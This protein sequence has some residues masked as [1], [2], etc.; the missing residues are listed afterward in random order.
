MARRTL[1]SQ[2]ELARLLGVQRS[3]VL[4]RLDYQGGPIPTYK[5]G[6]KRLVDKE[7]ALSLWSS[8]KRGQG[9]HPGATPD[10]PDEPD[11][12]ETD[13]LGDIF[14][15]NTSPVSAPAIPAPPS[16]GQ[17]TAELRLAILATKALSDK[18]AVERE[19]GNLVDKALAVRQVYSYA[20]KFRDGLQNLPARVGREIAAELGT[21]PALTTALLE[22]HV[23]EFL[24]D[25]ADQPVAIG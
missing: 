23:R 22:R 15:G 5:R 24:T 11:A 21:D 25:I 19:R 12:A 17:K 18:L 14:P 8:T 3:S 10:L 1:I 13:A 7:E 2:A 16:V 9:G 6:D 4:R 20:K